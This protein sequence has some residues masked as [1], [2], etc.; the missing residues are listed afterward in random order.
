MHPDPFSV[1]SS[2][3]ESNCKII[4]DPPPPLP[5]SIICSFTFLWSVIFRIIFHLLPTTDLHTSHGKYNSK[6]FRESFSFNLIFTS[7]TGVLFFLDQYLRRPRPHRILFGCRSPSW[8]NLTTPRFSF[9]HTD[10]RNLPFLF[11]SFTL[12][13]PFVLGLVSLETLKTL[14]KPKNLAIVSGNLQNPS[15]LRSRRNTKSLVRGLP[16]RPLPSVHSPS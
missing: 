8:P 12:V 2:V 9:G 5:L 13:S 14:Y 7:V 11:K 4:H 15:L 3:S 1:G 10:F 6:S 16:M